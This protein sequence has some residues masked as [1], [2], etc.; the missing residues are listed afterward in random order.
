MTCE[1][2]ASRIGRALINI[3]GVF[4]VQVSFRNR[5]AT[6]AFD[7]MLVSIDDV[8]QSDIFT[9]TIHIKRGVRKPIRHRY[10]AYLVY[11]KTPFGEDR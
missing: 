2:C 8:L 1:R 6:I 9:K 7:P 4:D 5:M 11:C 3:P 10:R